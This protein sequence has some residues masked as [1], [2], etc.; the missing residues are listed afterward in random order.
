MLASCGSDE[1]VTEPSTESESATSTESESATSTESESATSTVNV[2][3]REVSTI[4]IGN[5][6][7]MTEDLGK[8][9][10][11]DAKK[12]CADLGD[13]WRLPTKDELNILYQNKDKIGGFHLVVYWSSTEFDY[14]NAWSQHFF[15]GGQ[16][17]KGYDVN[18]I[19]NIPNSVRPVRSF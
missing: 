10:W 9:D 1:V 15:L 6:E 2:N 19:K 13:G 18:T 8:M 12:A 7:V 3:G 14:G 11:E 5:L 17:Q 4:K 16:Y